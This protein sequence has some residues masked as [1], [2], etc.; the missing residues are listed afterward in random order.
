MIDDFFKY[1]T[2]YDNRALK[3]FAKEK[4]GG[5][6]VVSLKTSSKKWRSDGLGKQTEK[7]MKIPVDIGIQNKK[8]EFIYLEKHPVNSQGEYKVEIDGKKGKPYKAGIDPLNK[9]ID[10]KPD[11]NEILV[12]FDSSF[13][14]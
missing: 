8:G 2:F 3:A 10:R 12:K 5:R 14:Q 13:V 1:I 9:L 4:P 11:D 6:Y 7:P